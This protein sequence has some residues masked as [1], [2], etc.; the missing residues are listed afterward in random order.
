M[1]PHS[2]RV[3]REQG[4]VSTVQVVISAAQLREVVLVPGFASRF[5]SL[6]GAEERSLVSYRLSALRFR[7][8]GIR[9]FPLGQPADRMPVPSCYVTSFDATALP[10]FSICH[11]SPTASQAP[12]RR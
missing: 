4:Q 8:M 1:L 9:S 7:R 5:Q 6:P 10:G 2:T 11:F 12:N 3:K